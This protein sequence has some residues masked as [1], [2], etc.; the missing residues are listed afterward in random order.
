[1]GCSLSNTAVRSEYMEGDFALI[2]RGLRESV[3]VTSVAA[4]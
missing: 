4:F 2:T 1:M 3:A